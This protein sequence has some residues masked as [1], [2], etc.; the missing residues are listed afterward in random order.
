MLFNVALLNVAL[1]SF[2]CLTSTTAADSGRKL[3]KKG[4]KKSLEGKYFSEYNFYPGPGAKLQVSANY[5]IFTPVDGA[6]DVFDWVECFSIDG[7]TTFTKSK[8]GTV[9]LLDGTNYRINV[10]EEE[11]DLIDGFT[12]I[13]SIAGN[14]RLSYG[15]FSFFNTGTFKATGKRTDVALGDNGCPLQ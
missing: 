8:E 9:V 13:G 11:D 12:I 3:S 5:Q 7:G 10:L 2:Y 14:N 1:I 15:L 4:K 6:P